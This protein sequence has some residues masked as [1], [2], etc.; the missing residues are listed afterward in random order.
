MKKAITVIVNAETSNIDVAPNEIL[1]DVL[2]NKIG[3]KSPKIGCDRGDCGACTIFLD[4][5]TVLSCLILA[6]E[7]D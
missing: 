3:V 4:G 1:L 2:R 5:K 7:A 6:V